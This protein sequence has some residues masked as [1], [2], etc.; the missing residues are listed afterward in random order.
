MLYSVVILSYN[1][2]RTLAKC[3]ASLIGALEKYAEPSEV[4]VVENGS[5]DGSQAI[6]N[7][8]KTT[9]PNLIKTILFNKNTGTT[10]S[11]NSA[12][13]RV[14]GKY[15]L[16]L[17]SDAFIDKPALDTLTESLDRETDIGLVCP[18]LRYRD[19]RFQMSTDEFPTL[20]RKLQRFLSLS[21]MQKSTDVYSLKEMDVDYAISACWLMSRQAVE[22]AGLFD[23][24]I[25]YS[26]EDVDYCISLWKAGFRLRY[27]PQAHVIHDAQELSRGFKITAFHLSH[28]KGL[29]YLFWKHKYFFS[30]KGIQ[31]RLRRVG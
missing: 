31:T 25:F 15:V 7:A 6:L 5:T 14:Q 29:F 3:L 12:L 8:F 13:S 20:G 2:E 10:H 27:I 21:K 22:K 4:F 1:A 23:E 11:R 17:D 18:Q 28:L 19:G 24:K 30:P 26:P 16:I 9:Y